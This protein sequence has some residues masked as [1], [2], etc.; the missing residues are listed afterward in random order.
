MGGEELKQ[1]KEESPYASIGG[2]MN[3]GG[4]V[5]PFSKNSYKP[6]QTTP[7]KISTEGPYGSHANLVFTRSK[8]IPTQRNK[9]EEYRAAHAAGLKAGTREAHVHSSQVPPSMFKQNPG[10]S[11]G[12]GTI[13]PTNLDN[14]INAGQAKIRKATRHKSTGNKSTGNESTYYKP[15]TQIGF[16]PEIPSKSSFQTLK[17]FAGKARNYIGNKFRTLKSKFPK[18]SKLRFGKRKETAPVTRSEESD[19]V[20]RELVD[21]GVEKLN[22]LFSNE[23]YTENQLGPQVPTRSSRPSGPNA[24]PEFLSPENTRALFSNPLP[25]EQRLLRTNYM[26]GKQNI[27]F[28]RPEE[29]DYQNPNTGAIARSSRTNTDYE[30]LSNEISVDFEDP[31]KIEG[32]EDPKHNPPIPPFGTGYGFGRLGKNREILIQGAQNAPPPTKT[33]PSVV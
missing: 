5:K 32:Y 23:S 9:N 30:L 13:S 24:G 16:V 20:Y 25:G 29:F 12:W 26:T 27:V 1:V 21:A 11:Q 2:V 18:L 22:P 8:I 6:E 7:E 4:Y 14:V 19:A 28:R 33:R 17:H 3:P 15:T 10:N 31:T